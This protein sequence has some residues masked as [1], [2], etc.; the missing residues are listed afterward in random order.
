MFRGRAYA[1]FAL[2]C[3][4][5]STTWLA[6][7][8]GLEDLPPVGSAALRFLV[9][10]PILLVIA[11]TRGHAF[12]KTAGEW[13]LP[14]Q[15]GVTM[16]A[17]PFALIYF[18]ERTVPSGLAA[19]LF[20][21]HAIFV[22]VFAHFT[23]EDEPLTRMRT[24]G[25]L[26]GFLGVVLVFRDRM[27][28]ERSWLGEAALVA[29]AAIQGTSSIAIRK[30]GKKTSAIVLS[31]I[32]VG[33][34]ALLLFALSTALGE[35]LWSSLTLEGVAT[36]VYLAVFGSVIAFTATI[37]L[38]HVL[39][40]NKVAMMSYMTPVLALVWGF[41]VLGETLGRDLWLGAALV[42]LGVWLA[43]RAPAPRSA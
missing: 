30:H 22:A 9:A 14:L 41:L 13:R 31:C 12:P 36:V 24:A 43:G 40:S 25:V 16:F 33:F 28:G 20:A 32:G 11:R 3:L 39:G 6:I 34:A 35:S 37:H 21:S 10:F 23:L 5:F 1:L 29:T 19:V 17:V 2:V 7:R 27:M 38:I 42:V 15:L 26:I 4:I 8:I 18:A